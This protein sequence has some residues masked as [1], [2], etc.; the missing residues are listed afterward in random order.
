MTHKLTLLS[1]LRMM[2]GSQWPCPSIWTSFSKSTGSFSCSSQDHMSPVRTKG[3]LSRHRCSHTPAPQFSSSCETT[4]NRTTRTHV[5]LKSNLSLKLI[6][7][8][9][10]NLH[11]FWANY[12]LSLTLRKEKL[13]YSP[14]IFVFVYVVVST[15]VGVVV[16]LCNFE[17]KNS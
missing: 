2:L 4:G 12:M 5:I 11:N 3:S 16:Q 9:C 13:E 7:F 15:R 14:T 1:L 10:N 8:K 17:N 6:S